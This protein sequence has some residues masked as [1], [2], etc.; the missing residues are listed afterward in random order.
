MAGIELNWVAFK[1]SFVY[2]AF[3][4]SFINWSSIYDI[5]PFADPAEHK[6]TSWGS[7]GG[8][9]SPAT[10]NYVIFRAKRSW[11]GQRHLRENIKKK[12]CWC[13]FQNSQNKFLLFWSSV[14]LDAPP[15][16]CRPLSGFFS[17]LVPEVVPCAYR[18]K[19]YI[20]TVADLKYRWLDYTRWRVKTLVLILNITTERQ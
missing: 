13:D 11:F 18:R 2:L 4:T 5:Y 8:C 17:G 10:Q 1:D 15:G 7:E 20:V 16:V 12:C 9:S 6:H 19:C 3:A 14:W